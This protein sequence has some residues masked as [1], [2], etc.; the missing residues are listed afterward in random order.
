MSEKTRTG[1]SLAVLRKCEI[2]VV[3]VQRLRGGMLQ[4]MK[5]NREQIIHKFCILCLLLIILGFLRKNKTCVCICVNM[6]GFLFKV[7]H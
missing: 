3:V 5:E 6:T 4:G 7:P 1:A 2:D